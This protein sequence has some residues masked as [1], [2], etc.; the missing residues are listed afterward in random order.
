MLDHGFY[1]MLVLFDTLFGHSPLSAIKYTDNLASA[2][3]PCVSTILCAGSDQYQRTRN[4][5]KR[6]KCKSKE[7]RYS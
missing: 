2:I 3:D 4:T 1:A 5:R 6:E 7:G